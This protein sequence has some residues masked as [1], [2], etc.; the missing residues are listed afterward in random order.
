MGMALTRGSGELVR[1]V[2]AETRHLPP[3]GIARSK[4]CLL[5]YH[6]AR[7]HHLSNL[8]HSSWTLGMGEAEREFL[9]AH[10]RLRAAYKAE[11]LDILDLDA[12]DTQLPGPPT[13]L[14]LTV[15]ATRDARDVV[16]DSGS[17]SLRKGE[18][19]RVSRAEVLPLIAKGWLRIV[20]D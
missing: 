1:T 19:A 7:L 2:I 13:D 15:Q 5:A 12:P 10:A 8:S 14:M 6:A 9:H 16:T 4:R 11:F 18:R 17:I 20:K 3:A